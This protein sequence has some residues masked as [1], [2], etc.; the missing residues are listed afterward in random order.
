[1][2]EARDTVEAG[3]RDFN[4]GDLDGLM[5]RYADDAT[6]M[7]SGLP[8]ELKG[9][10]QIRPFIQMYFTA[11][12]GCQLT[13]KNV[14]ESGGWVVVEWVFTGTH[15]GPFVT[16]T[17]EIP[18]TGKSVENKAVSVFEV[19][20]G[21]VVA[22]RVYFDTMELMTQLGMMPATTSPAT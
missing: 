9:K 17:G 2:G 4:A 21:K 15:N 3:L 13:P 20:N 12:P 8:A 10:D 16:P 22:Q 14:I 18:A 19:R 1:M 6:A 5:A 7:V 11:F